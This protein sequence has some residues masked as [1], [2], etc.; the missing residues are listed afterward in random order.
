[1]AKT[2]RAEKHRC[3]N[4][5]NYAN[6]DNSKYGCCKKIGIAD[7]TNTATVEFPNIITGTI[8]N[9]DYCVTSKTEL[10]HI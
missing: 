8:F 2:S 1:M 5:G 6:I 7:N 4:A 10:R 3:H 9:A